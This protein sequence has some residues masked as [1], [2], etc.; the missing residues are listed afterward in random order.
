MAYISLVLALILSV[1]LLGNSSTYSTIHRILLLR[2]EDNANRNEFLDNFIASNVSQY[3]PE[4]FNITVLEVQSDSPPHFN[5]LAAFC[6]QIISHG[7]SVIISLDKQAHPNLIDVY[8][9]Y[10]GI[11]VLKIFHSD[12]LKPLNKV[13]LTNKHQPSADHLERN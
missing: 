2:H 12:D 11:P 9:S 10:A 8:A 13:C 1:C 7:V 6:E 4:L 3:R 5:T